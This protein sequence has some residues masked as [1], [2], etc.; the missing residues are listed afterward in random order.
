[1]LSLDSVID[2]RVKGRARATSSA[3]KPV[4]SRPWT[5]LVREFCVVGTEEQHR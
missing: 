4:N 2:A 3:L 1:M 5:E